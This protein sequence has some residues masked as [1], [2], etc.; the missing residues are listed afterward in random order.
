MAHYGIG[1]LTAPTILCELGDVTRLS[2]S[3]KAVRCA[4]LD[5]GV[6]RSD[7]RSRAGKL[8]RQGFAAA[9]LGALRV[10]PSGLQTHQPRPR[11]LPG[12]QGARPLA[13]P[14]LAD[15]R[16]QARAAL[17][18]H[19]ARTR[20]RRLGTRHLTRADPG[21]RPAWKPGMVAGD[22]RRPAQSSSISDVA[23]PRLGEQ[24]RASVASHRSVTETEVNT[25]PRRG[26]PT[27]RCSPK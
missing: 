1:E 18:P 8:T 12:A 6:H 4:G 16:P 2:A 10:S 24:L 19:A 15:D 14:G 9:A 17:L 7:R 25:E 11:R 5:I 26:A 20:P 23:P 13:H 3:R 22:R 27:I 21:G